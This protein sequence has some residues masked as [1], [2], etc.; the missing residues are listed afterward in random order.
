M[1]L[2]DRRYAG[3]YKRR[4]MLSNTLSSHAICRYSI[5]NNSVAA[6]SYKSVRDNQT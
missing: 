5:I 1:Q 2:M 4:I 3:N 6:Y